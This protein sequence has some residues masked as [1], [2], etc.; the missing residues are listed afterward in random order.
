MRVFT[1]DVMPYL[2]HRAKPGVLAPDDAF[3][4][5]QD[6]EPL[7]RSCRTAAPAAPRDGMRAR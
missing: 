4:D 2:H 6:A 7:T 1:S 3:Y 5:V